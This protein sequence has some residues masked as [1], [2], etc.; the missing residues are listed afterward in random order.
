[1][2]NENHVLSTD[3]QI[4]PTRKHGRSETTMCNWQ[5]ITLH[6]QDPQ[7]KVVK[8]LLIGCYPSPILVSNPYH[9]LDNP[10]RYQNPLVG[11]RASLHV[12]TPHISWT[13]NNCSP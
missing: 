8:K 9:H 5:W 6:D 7:C 3:I 10:Y 4:P 2:L 12:F 1:M 13:T 11:F